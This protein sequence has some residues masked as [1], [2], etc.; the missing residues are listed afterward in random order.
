LNFVYYGFLLF[1]L[2]L[3]FALILLFFPAILIFYFYFSILYY[4]YCFINLRYSYFNWLKY[5]NTNLFNILLALWNYCG[6]S[7]LVVCCWLGYCK[8]WLLIFFVFVFILLSEFKFLLP[9]YFYFDINEGILFKLFILM[10]FLLI[11][12]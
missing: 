5:S 12:F 10:L 11:K 8:S 1:W 6:R 4:L 3:L 9:D 2:V 7:N